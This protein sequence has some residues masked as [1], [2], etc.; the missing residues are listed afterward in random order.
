MYIKL[1][2]HT[3]TKTLTKYPS[4]KQTDLRKNEKQLKNRNIKKYNTQM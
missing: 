2:T 1:Y 3:T 4:I